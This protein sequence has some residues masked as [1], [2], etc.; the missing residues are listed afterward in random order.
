MP[1]SLVSPTGNAVNG[2]L[3]RQNVDLRVTERV[4]AN[5]TRVAVNA[6]MIQHVDGVMTAQIRASENVFLEAIVAQWKNF[7]VLTINDG[8][9]R[10]AQIAN[11]TDIVSVVKTERHAYNLVAI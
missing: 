3:F 10:N 5:S 1:I 4:N 8:T 9:L 2:P 6:E 11:V 7:I